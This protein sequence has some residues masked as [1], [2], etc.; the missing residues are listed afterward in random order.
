M[1]PQDHSGESSPDVRFAGKARDAG[2][3]AFDEAGKAQL[4]FLLRPRLTETC[5]KH[6]LLPVTAL[7]LDA[8][9]QDI[10]SHLLAALSSAGS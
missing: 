7:F 5:Q 9:E 10:Q 4:G 1:Q 3:A 2:S 8:C 6:E